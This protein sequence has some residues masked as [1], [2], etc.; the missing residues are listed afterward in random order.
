M[1]QDE[2]MLLIKEGEGYLLEFKENISDIDREIVA[3]ANS[4]GGRLLIG[5]KDNGEIKSLNITNTLISEIHDIANNCDPKIKLNIDKVEDVLVLTVE[6]GKDKPYQCKKGY[7]IRVG[8]NT[9]KMK[10]DELIQFFID[11]NKKTYDS[12]INTKFSFEKDFD[13]EKYNRYLKLANITN[14]VDTKEVLESLGVMERG[15]FNNA[16]VLFFSKDPQRFF[17]NSVYTVALFRD[18]NGVDVIDRKEV[19]GSLFEIVEQ[20]MTFVKLYTKV[21]YK[22]TGAPQ[23][24]EINQ[25]SIEAVREAVIN[26]VMHK[27][28]LEPGH[29]NILKV[30]PDR[31]EIENYWLKPSHFI[32]GKTVFRR[33][34][35]ITDLFLRMDY[36]EKMGSGLERMNTICKKENSPLPE[37][38]V[39]ENYFYI[40][41]KQ[42][43]DYLELK[44]QES[45]QDVA[46]RSPTSHQDITS[47][48]TVVNER[49][50]LELI[51]Q[52]EKITAEE[53]A[54]KLSLS[55]RQILRHIARLKKK[56]VLERI[57]AHYGGYWR[58]KGFILGKSKLGEK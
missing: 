11:V 46:K 34:P 43:K 31:I 15:Y 14:V 25:F 41:F 48:L 39:K 55:K 44:A 58:I 57:G 30:L 16:G 1:N 8:S 42:N 54:E 3:F 27:Y 47:T 26:S 13:Y 45:H 24:I 17:L 19:K 12:V 20:V 49:E 51:S 32:L 21:A 10:R 2:L 23:R 38:D 50:L 9:V 56:D 6:E 22:F 33:N 37:I 52:N 28:Y 7:F 5:V 29:N 40:T 35:I 18:L 4:S 53:L 36:G